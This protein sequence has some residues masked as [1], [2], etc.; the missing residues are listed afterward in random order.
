MHPSGDS[1]DAMAHDAAALAD[2]MRALVASGRRAEALSLYARA[3][4]RLW[5][6]EGREPTAELRALQAEL[7]AEAVRAVPRPRDAS[8]TTSP[9]IRPLPPESS[10]SYV[11]RSGL[12]DSVVS[13]LAD[14]KVV[15]L[16]GPG[17]VGKTRIALNVAHRLA[18]AGQAA[19][20]WVDLAPARDPEGAL[21][22]AADAIGVRDIALDDPVGSL[23]RALGEEATVVVVDNCEHLLDVAA[24]LVDGLQARSP[25]TTVLATSREPLEVDGEHVVP[26]PALTASDD[27]PDSPALRLFDDRLATARGYGLETS[28]ID[29]AVAVTQRLDGLP[30]ALE[31]A[32][33]RG[34]A[35]GIAQLRERVG[36]D[37]LDRG[38]RTGSTRHRSLR[39]VVDWSYA[40]LGDAEQRLFARLSVFTG[41]FSL[42]RA[43]VVCADDQVPVARLPSLLSD[44]VD[45]SLVTT[46]RSDE[47]T[48]HRLLQPLR[49]YAA[50]RLESTG[51]AQ[52]WQTA[53]ARHMADVA[54]A[55][56]Q[57]M[58]GPG[59]PGATEQLVEDLDESR[60]A[61]EHAQSAGDIDTAM[62]LANA[63]HDLGSRQM[64]LELLGWAD[65]VAKMPDASDHPLYAAVL[66][67][68]AKG[69]WVRTDLEGAIARAQRAL[70]AV[71]DPSDGRR[72]RALL[73]MAEVNL[74]AG[75]LDTAVAFYR[76]AVDLDAAPG[77]S[78]DAEG[79]LA[80]TLAD[81]GRV[82]EGVELADRALARA[83]ASG[84]PSHLAWAWYAQGRCW[85][86]VDPAKAAT[87]LE[88][89]AELSRSVANH[90][91]EYSAL[92]RLLVVRAQLTPPGDLLPEYR[93][94]LQRW[95]RTGSTTFLSVTLRNLAAPLEQLGRTA[96]AEV[97]RSSAGAALS[98]P[99]GGARLD[100]AYAV[101]M[102]VIDRLAAATAS[103]TA[104]PQPR[105]SSQPRTGVFRLDGD[106]WTVGLDATEVHVAD[107]KG[108][109]DLAVLISRPGIE[110]H[111]LDLV[112]AGAT[113]PASIDDEPAGRPAHLGE[114][115]D[116]Q[117][118]RAYELRIREL[119]AQLDEQPDHPDAE[120]WQREMDFL[121][122]EL[123]AAYGLGK[124][125][126]RAGDPVEKA[127]SAVTWRIRHAIRRI[128]E[129]HPALGMH[130]KHSVRTG[131]Y[132]VYQ[133][134][135]EFHW[136]R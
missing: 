10:T 7:L 108:M 51:E 77:P 107:S 125:P 124:R 80:M 11:G 116:A 82:D 30:L 64:R 56:A 91:N 65:S 135:D 44:L 24:H 66:G 63:M 68:A 61:L 49:E 86:L 20:A 13:L 16:H 6:T 47:Q 9:G 93:A 8:S 58:H 22:A 70:D 78:T 45:R 106:V 117:A 94:T 69:R 84:A 85:A 110:V 48:R 19:V 67:T 128:S 120:R 14:A 52:R 115:V 114:V 127:R 73:A 21:Y 119:Q 71:P 121:V 75:E 103:R 109:Q 4:D 105:A 134:D 46:V 29:D 54:A 31:L 100:E 72:V 62:R 55:R 33:G 81:L 18:S 28:E 41:S 102:E 122:A 53:H 57:A 87:M 42:A 40:L 123:A 32:A 76:R 1:V 96:E 98:G 26:V 50:E 34:A 36:L 133:P 92:T 101:A 12:T 59:E 27:D 112:G 129:L 95:R 136:I 74:V 43:E 111:C 118:R 97:L 131:R 3:R 104:V 38:R 132:C 79:G 126:R 23:V 2:Q 90:S 15:T 37:L 99:A 60:V 130:L 113:S 89:S 39:A 35:L 5:E 17:G 25:R 88:R 83:E